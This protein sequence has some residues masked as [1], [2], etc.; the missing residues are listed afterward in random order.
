MK[1]NA[2]RRILNDLWD[3]VPLGWSEYNVVTK[4]GRAV[5]G[6]RVDHLKRIVIVEQR[7]TFIEKRVDV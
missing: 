7:D 5:T 1:A 3:E 6:V 2:L 4:D